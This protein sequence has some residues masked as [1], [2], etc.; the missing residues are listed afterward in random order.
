MD[1]LGSCPPVIAVRM[2][3]I[4]EEDETVH[5][6]KIEKKK[7]KKQLAEKVKEKL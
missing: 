1:V 6:V 2:D 3:Y 7:K 5:A 4:E